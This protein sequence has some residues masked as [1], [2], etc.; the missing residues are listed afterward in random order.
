MGKHIQSSRDQKSLITSVP[1]RNLQEVQKSFLK[2]YSI[3]SRV[4]VWGFKVGGRGDP[5]PMWKEGCVCWFPN[6]G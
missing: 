6:Q 1:K 4:V 5:L 3:G 2:G